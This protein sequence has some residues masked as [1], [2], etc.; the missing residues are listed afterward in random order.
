MGIAT[1]RAGLS[2][3]TADMTTDTFTLDDLRTVLRDAAGDG[4]GLDGDILDVPLDELGYDSV[5]L[6]ETSGRIERERGIALDDS[7]LSGAVTPRAFIAA[8]NEQLAATAAG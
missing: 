7:T 4:D 2:K 1:P 3:G 5:S 6:L 8:V